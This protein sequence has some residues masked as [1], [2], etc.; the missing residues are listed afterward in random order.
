M[1]NYYK[2]FYD[3]L[4][5]RNLPVEILNNRIWLS[6][7][8][9]FHPFGPAAYDYSIN[10]DEV[11]KLLKRNKHILVMYTDGFGGNKNMNWYAVICRSFT[12]VEKIT[13]SKL[14]SEVKRGLKNVSAEV[15]SAEFIADNGYEAFRN[16]SL[17]Y[18]KNFKITQEE[19]RKSILPASDYN[20]IV[21]YWAVFYQNK[22]V[23]FSTV[24]IYGS[25]EANY[26]SIKIDPAYSGYYP[27]YSLIYNMN[28]YYL[29]ELK[30]D[31]TNDGYRTILHST[32]IQD[33]LI[34]KFNFKKEFTNI[35]VHFHPVIKFGL[36]TAS[37]LRASGSKINSH[38]KALYSLYDLSK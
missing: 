22:L 35:H 10:D 9:V 14:R 12:P 25:I 3:Y 17:R 31:Y 23:G 38:I 13:N 34:K 29:N 15:V 8:F 16:A 5:S 11:K 2:R 32:S 36:K 19:F 7:R 27:F 18:S 1:E 20:D 21:N 28:K 33:F 24:L 4:K 37:P 6:E 30:F 26:S